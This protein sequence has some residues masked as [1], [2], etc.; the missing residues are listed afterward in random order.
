M[1]R[2]LLAT[3][4]ATIGL[5]GVLPAPAIAAP[6]TSQRITVQNFAFQ[7]NT[8]FSHDKLK[9]VVQ[10]WLGHPIGFDDLLKVR[11]AITAH[12]SKRDM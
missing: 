9:Q 12:Y 8:A 10:S 7:G 4:A 1:R 6:E 2:N 11:E 3:I 5:I